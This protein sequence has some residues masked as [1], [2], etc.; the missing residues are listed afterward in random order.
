M[1]AWDL[2]K[3]GP[4]IFI[5]WSEFNLVSYNINKINTISKPGGGEAYK[6]PNFG[7]LNPFSLC[8]LG[9]EIPE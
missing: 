8:Y 6:N 3:T 4:C 2:K 1:N 9:N 7:D 5:S